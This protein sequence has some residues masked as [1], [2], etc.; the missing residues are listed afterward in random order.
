M[1]RAWTIR[2]FVCLLMGVVTTVASSWGAAFLGPPEQHDAVGTLGF[3]GADGGG[4]RVT[5]YRS[6]GI[7]RLAS[8]ALFGDQVQRM[9]EQD[10]AYWESPQGD[11]WSAVIEPLVPADVPSWSR[12]CDPPDASLKGTVGALAWEY[13]SGWPCRA[14]IAT[15]YPMSARTRGPAEGPPRAVGLDDGVK[16]GVAI[17]IR[18]DTDGWVT[19]AR[20][21]PVRPIWPGFA[22]DIAL[23]TMAWL[24]SFVVV[25]TV[26]STARRRRGRCPRC[27]YDLRHL[28]RA[29]CPECGRSG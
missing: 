11:V 9:E 10:A 25:T 29:A 17:S 6:P 4:W 2:I 14:L 22:I 12:T 1:R 13:A 20:V 26:R 15:C 28:E 19:E 3:V 23:F 21:L 24:A 8:M 7:T 5:R 16:D 27:G 18:R